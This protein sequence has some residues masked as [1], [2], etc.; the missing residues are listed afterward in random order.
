MDAIVSCENEN[1][2]HQQESVQ[3]TADPSTVRND[4]PVE[5]ASQ[6]FDQVDISLKGVLDWDQFCRIVI[7]GF[8]DMAW[9]TRSQLVNKFMAV[10]T[11]YNNG[12][13]IQK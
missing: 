8:K 13:K 6:E 9:E 11:D 12:Q 1:N 2:D 3:N 4:D 10:F 5:A 7:K